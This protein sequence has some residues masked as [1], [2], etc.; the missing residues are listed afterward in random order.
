MSLLDQVTNEYTIEVDLIGDAIDPD[1][2]TAIMGFNPTESGRIGDPRKNG[3][4]GAVHERSF[5]TYDA[6][7]H[8]DVGECRDHQLRLLAEQI[9][10]KADQ[11]REAGVERIYFYYTLCSQIGLMNIHF[12]AETLQKVSDIGADLYVSCYDCFNPNDPIWKEDASFQEEQEP[13]NPS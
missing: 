6:T 1:R 9:G 5:W 11:L 3:H 2:I 8:D 13:A 10:P 4:E 7:N 12:K